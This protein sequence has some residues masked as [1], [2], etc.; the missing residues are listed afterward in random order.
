VEVLRLS[1]QL[2]S[3][4]SRAQ[5]LCRSVARVLQVL[6]IDT[7]AVRSITNTITLYITVSNPF[8]HPQSTAQQLTNMHTSSVLAIQ[9]LGIP[10]A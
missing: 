10:A 1:S 8:L 4:E 5:V 6:R 9:L 2:L 3:D 7:L